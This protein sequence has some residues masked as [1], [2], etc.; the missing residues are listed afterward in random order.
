MNRIPLWGIECLREGFILY[1]YFDIYLG[2]DVIGKARVFQ[3]GLFFH[4]QCQC[5]LPSQTV[6]HV[7][8]QCGSKEFDLGVGVP[9][10][11]YLSYKRI[12][13]K[14]FENTQFRFYIA[15]KKK[16]VTE[17]VE[18]DSEKPFA[19]FE[20][21]EFAKLDTSEEKPIICL[22]LPINSIPLQPDSDPIQEF[23]NQ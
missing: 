5:S 12:S 9:T 19:Y 10:E 20:Q 23:Q 1:N 21:L 8:L 11:D 3:E 18:V 16:T 2:Q 15:E 14:Q 17:R 13:I 6:Y 7:I 4:F 22:E